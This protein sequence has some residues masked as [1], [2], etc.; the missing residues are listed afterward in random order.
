[1][2]YSYKIRFLQKKWILTCSPDERHSFKKLPILPHWLLSFYYNSLRLFAGMLL[3]N[4]RIWY[5]NWL[6]ND[7]SFVLCH[8]CKLSLFL[9]YSI[10]DSFFLLQRF[11]WQRRCFLFCSV[12]FTYNDGIFVFILKAPWYNLCAYFC[13]TK[14]FLNNT[15]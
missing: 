3:V 12:F 14:I 8:K 7:R 10:V 2:W 5:R 13:F 11:I 6:S 15:L 4:K 9:F 1:M